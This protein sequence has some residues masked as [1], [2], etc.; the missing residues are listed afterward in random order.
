MSGKRGADQTADVLSLD[1]GL[2]IQK[3]IP[4]KSRRL[5]DDR[6]ASLPVGANLIE[7]DGKSCTHEVAWPP[8][9]QGSTQPPP[10]F[11]T[12]PARSYAFKLD[13]FQQTAI[14]ALEA[15]HSVLVAAHTS[16]GKTVVAEYAFAMA[17]R[18][19]TRVIYTSPLK[20]LSNQK[21]RELYEEFQDVGLMTGDV[22]INPEASCLVMTTEILRS[23]L[24]R[25]SEVVR[26]V[27]LLV[28]DEIHY[29]R[30]KE[31]GVVWEESIILAPKSCRFAFLS[32]TIPNA[33]EF[34]LWIAKTHG[35]PC[36]VVY[37]DYRPTPLQHYIHPTGANELY[38]VVDERGVFREDNF[39]K[40]VATVHDA[41]ADGGKKQK[42]K[43]G[44]SANN[45][46]GSGDKTDIF[47]IV[48]MII[49]RNYDPVIVFSFSKKECEKL[50]LSMVALDLTDK[51]EK[52]LVESIFKNAL[53]CLSMEDRKVPQ[54][55]Q[56]LPM[57]KRGI[58]VHHSGLLPIVKEVIEIMFQE[59][60]LKVLFA[61]ETFS[62]GLNMPAKTVVFTNVRK[63]D[64]GSFRWVSSGEYIQMSGRAG[65]RGLDD[66]GIVILMLDSKMESG[67]AKDMI[68]GAP[69]TMYSEFHLGYNML[70]N[71]LRIEGC[72][73]EQLMA[74]SFRQFQLERSLPQLE[75]KARMLQARC[76]E[77]KIDKEDQVQ[78]Y[79]LLL[80]RFQELQAEVRTVLSAPQH[81]LPFLQPG[82]LVRVLPE[83]Q[84]TVMELPDF[85]NLT[86]ED[87]TAAGAVFG[88]NLAGGIVATVNGGVWGAVVA[89][90]RIGKKGDVA[91]ESDRPKGAAKY[92]VDVLV[93]TSSDR[94][95]VAASGG[96]GAGPH[97]RL[98]LL[99]PQ[100][101]HLQPQVVSISLS[102]VDALSS[103]RVFI[104]KDLRSIDARKIGIKCVGE[105]ISRLCEKQG[106]VPLLDLKEDMKVKD[107]AVDKMIDKLERVE[108]ELKEHPLASLPESRCLLSELQNKKKL[109]VQAKAARRDVKAAESLIL[110]D[111][112]KHMQRVLRRLAYVDS[113]GVI[114]IKGKVAAS[115]SSGHELVIT[116]LIFNGAFTDLSAEQLLAACSCFVCQEK[117][118]EDQKISEGMQGVLATVQEAARRVAR[119]S[120]E[121]RIE[122]NEQDFV[123]TFRP[124][125]MEVVAAWSR[126]TNFSEI[127]KMTSV[128]E[129][130]IV[131]SIRRLE[132]LMRE[133][134]EA[135]KSIGD[136]DMAERFETASQKIKRDV[137]FA[138]SLYL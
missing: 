66:R 130:S 47:K 27:Q 16:A 51:D 88:E 89:F 105:A 107:K 87:V 19:K 14:N 17:L 97:S 48:K 77:L 4:A 124:T 86:D 96:D 126:G 32:A 64:G 3:E 79:F 56:I 121:S 129:G 133:L 95:L 73:P 118:P 136:A 13:P 119:A 65:R 138:A 29:L 123:D 115:I 110:K 12:L 137:I 101:K 60:L 116:E 70:L 67:V 134:H 100:T 127:L 25:G 83:I 55:S 23:M 58:G 122:M 94:P 24:Y 46:D 45:Q 114:T 43:G 20:A 21:Y 2:D 99:P 117:M 41:A 42:G 35:S 22:T 53:E 71:L 38:M 61:T 37:T 85:G 109:E 91:S 92:I 68:K 98:A 33:K 82:R 111:D 54:I 57:L 102:Q 76:D 103:I 26:E 112:L 18:D 40:A 125:L 108:R 93:N 50:A 59:G 9:E 75:E 131:R 36:H 120:I 49:E 30:D 7:C 128:F 135:L 6:V 8:H 34:A 80:Q 63:Y 44:A 104:Q 11:N 81:S 113:Q 74:A 62:T 132:E 78:E 31:R 84:P 106:K 10:S 90:E 69:D 52:V 28:Y 72:E 39:Q 15:G 5:A 1:A